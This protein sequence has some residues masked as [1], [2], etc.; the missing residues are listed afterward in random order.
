M[1]RLGNVLTGTEW[2]ERAW[3]YINCGKSSKTT[4][5][6]CASFAECRPMHSPAGGSRPGRLSGA[7]RKV[8]ENG[9]G[10]EITPDDAIEQPEAPDEHPN[11]RKL[12][13]RMD[14]VMKQSDPAGV[15]HASA[16]IF[17]TLAKD[18]VAAPTVQSQTLA[19]FFD[20][21]RK[22]SGLPSAIL[23]YIL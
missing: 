5:A 3:L 12:V 10:V 17:E 19:S 20:R 16:S 9:V 21:Y 2:T 15:L 8:F 6:T 13:P 18:V 7:I 4:R 14:A 22:T 23:D 11:V 1:A